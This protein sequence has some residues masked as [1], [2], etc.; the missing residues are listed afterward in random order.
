M[1]SKT[2]QPKPATISLVTISQD[3]GEGSAGFSPVAIVR[4]Q[5]GL[6]SSEGSVGA[7]HAGWLPHMAGTYFWEA[8]EWWT[9][10][11]RCS[12]PSTDVLG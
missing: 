2:W 7:R 1:Y 4:W 9:K 3:F 5:L 8:A 11:P 6:L 12:F 10:V